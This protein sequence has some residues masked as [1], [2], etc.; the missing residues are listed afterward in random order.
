[1]IGAKSGGALSDAAARRKIVEDL[2]KTLF[3]E[4]GAGSGKT[5][6]LVDR[7][8]A[9]LCAGR[10]GIG[11]LAAVTF[12][13][14]AAAELRGRFQ[15]ELERRLAREADVQVKSRLEE[16]LQ[17]LEQCYIGTIH[18]FCAKLL[19]ERPIEI[20]LDPD[21]VEMEEIEDQVF[22]EKCWNDYMVKVRLEEEKIV[23]GLEEVGLAPEDLKGAFEAVALYPEVEIIGGS[24]SI[25]DFAKLKN[26]L[27]EFLELARK[28]MPKQKPDK[29]YDGLQKLVARCF[30]RQDK[31]GFD[32]HRLLMETFEF[33]DKDPGVT[34]NRWRDRECAE[35]AK[36]EFDT[37]RESAISQALRAWREYRH[38]RIVRFLG[39]A[40][41]YYE[42]RRREENKLNFEDLL[43]H[44]RRLLRD[45]PEVRR[46]FSR[47][48]THI[49][50]DE[51]QDTDPIQAE[52]LLY[53]KGVDVEERDWQKARIAPGSLFLVGDPKQSIYRFRRADIDTYN[54][55]KKIA[56]ESGG[57]VLSLTSNFRS[58]KALAQWNNPIFKIAFPAEAT[59][60][61]AAFAPLDTV[62][63]EE[64]GTTCGVYK[65][66]MP[67]VARNKG[68][69]IAEADAA[70]I[71]EWIGKACGEGKLRLS[72]SKEEVEKGLGAEAQPRDFMIL[73]RYKKF[74][75]VYA[76]ALEERGIPFEITG[77]NA[78]V[79]SEEIGEIT[80]LATALNDPDNPIYAV[81]VLRGIFF[82]VSDNDLMAFRR[83]GGRFNFMA[84]ARDIVE[85]K[86]VGAVNV[87]LA[88]AKM[89]EWRGWTLKMPPSAA[90]EKIFE[91]TGILNYLAS[92]EVGSSRVG[93]MLK[94]LELLR[95]EERKG[96]T[97][98]AG[99][100]ELL[101]EL[102]EVGDIEEI[103][104]TPGRENAVRLMNLHK[105][106]GL[107]APVVFLANPVGMKDH[108]VE[109]HV[110]RVEEGKE[111]GKAEMMGTGGGDVG[112]SDGAGATDR[113]D[114]G[115]R[116]GASGQEG[117]G[118]GGRGRDGR[119]DAEADAEIE[120]RGD[121][122]GESQDYWARD[123]GSEGRRDEDAGGTGDWECRG[124]DRGR[125]YGRPKAW[126]TFFKP[127]GLYQ[128]AMLSQPC[129]WEEKAEEE[130]RYEEAEEQRLMYVASTRARN[131]LVISTY[132]GEMK[133]KAWATLDAD[134]AEV[135][136]LDEVP[137][138]EEGAELEMGGETGEGRKEEGKKKEA[139][140]PLS[141][142]EAGRTVVPGARE[143]VVIT[144]AEVERARKEVGETGRA[145]PRKR[146]RVVITKA[147]V[148]RA[149]KEISGNIARAGEPSYQVESVTSV[150]KREAERPSWQ[151]GSSGMGLSWGRVVHQVL[152][153]I[154]T[155]RLFFPLEAK[156]EALV[157]KASA[158]PHSRSSLAEEVGQGKDGRATLEL[159]IENLLVAEE[160]DLADKDKLIALVDSILRS[161]F[162]QRVM[163]AERRY[164][165]IPFS[166]KTTESE[167]GA[168][169]T[170]IK[171]SNKIRRGNDLSS[172][173]DL[174]VILTGTID[175]VFWE[176]GAEGK[177]LG[178]SKD[179][180]NRNHE[181][182]E[183]DRGERDDGYEGKDRIKGDDE[184]SAKYIEEGKD[185]GEGE[186]GREGKDRSEGQ[187]GKDGGWIIA[188]YK[189]DVI[190]GAAEIFK[191]EGPELTMEKIRRVSPEF[192][193][194]IDFYAPQIRL[195]TKFWS[196]ITGEPVKES[197]L[198]FTALNK[199]INIFDWMEQD[200]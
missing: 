197:G 44:A 15:I 133:N 62:R 2:D 80:N 146:E 14:K 131:M 78:F 17:N 64:A 55:L 31:L 92:R 105:A 142:P 161:E 1:M 185:F 110:V 188:D 115:R 96:A 46:Y 198:Y 172:I 196:Q 153:A 12:T 127:S 168:R 158:S 27:E 47:K 101:E 79:E 81:A 150:A 177:N 28:L 37:F 59:R 4:A 50:V 174:P 86:S 128:K 173:S 186:K 118:G 104:L 148:E 170:S 73:Y 126:F 103:S 175:L 69:E 139:G 40:I 113:E 117:S 195:Y 3:V 156:D 11:T 163:R 180:G 137:E 58:L 66:I 7:M 85:S 154:G 111:S 89:R 91:E 56:V 169:E 138:L 43:M 6:S 190:P 97:S 34:L 30:G 87:G 193:R 165:E 130:K 179:R 107:E 72:R 75:S 45:N 5:K 132:A 145:A 23:A 38:D 181:N 24:A 57:E 42:D 147:E 48:F 35:A 183:K 157:T 106:K 84:A 20:G 122:G 95:N 176:N 53:L 184:K 178:E 167:L 123:K 164:F 162:W 26:K 135:P 90:L 149:R 151:R 68:E 94:L 61:Q 51:L 125:S 65:I 77:S 99:A 41:Q 140:R 22:Q 39:P 100:V 155:G 67:K 71:A 83:E 52:M 16:A 63:E 189:T 114:G 19:R 98:F 191:S 159:Y 88:M 18:S 120:G 36:R 152:E 166:I 121:R 13:R 160:R 60:Y 70:A 49:L 109:K 144:K 32:D 194:V 29:G 200:Y 119:G 187:E 143:K 82:G 192:A 102:A 10:C 134:L 141:T 33:L 136:E 182:A 129:G 124:G 74:M 25:P 116:D 108:P 54:L 112:K 21:F 93:N 9:L 199:W 76:R 171:G 8:I